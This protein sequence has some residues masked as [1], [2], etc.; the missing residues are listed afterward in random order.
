MDVNSLLATGAIA[1]GGNM[2]AKAFDGPF[3]SISD[4]W[5]IH[6]GYKTDI[7]R[8]E[9]QA[10]VKLYEQDILKKLSNV[11]PEN[12]QEPRLSIIG[13]ALEESKYYV[14]EPELREMFANL[15]ASA[16]DITKNEI[17]HPSFVS[18]IKQMSPNDATLLNALLYYGPMVSYGLSTKNDINGFK[19]LMNDVCLESLTRNSIE[20][21]S[22]SINNLNRLGIITIDRIQ[23]VATSGAYDAFFKHPL[24]NKCEKYLYENSKDFLSVK[25]KKMTYIVNPYG[26]YFKAVC[27]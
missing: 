16:A 12:Y 15:I 8:V 24:Y 21:D 2:F 7:Q 6:F 11:A 14:E 19:P 13:P 27:L 17:I 9:K 18:V 3:K 22:V 23:N 25:I 5:Y 1:V 4:L 10:A 26:E 20:L